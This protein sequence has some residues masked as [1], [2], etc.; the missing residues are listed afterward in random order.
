MAFKKIDV[1]NLA[2][3][4]VG[5]K[6]L[7]GLTDA[8]KAARLSNSL[9]E[10]SSRGMMELPENWKFLTARAELGQNSNEPISGV[11]SYQY[12]IP[13]KC[14]RVIANHD[15]DDDKIEF[16]YKREVYVSGS[17]ETDVILT[18]QD[19]CFIR[20]IRERVDV[21]RWPA[22]FAR[23]VA[24]D[25]AIVLCEP[26][27]QDKPKKNQLLAMMTEPAYGWLAKAIQANGL[28]DVDVDDN[29]VSLDKGNNDVINAAGVTEV[30][31]RYIQ[32]RE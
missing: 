16:P 29:N 9:Y 1:V 24:L 5:A 3:V 21:A 8:S 26:L 12:N 22:W 28:E 15:A 11:Y 13:P 23:I 20:Y 7:T 2:M 6:V 18:N 25:L 14:L 10:L 17:A 4:L 32:T 31:R 30:I 19:T 27:K